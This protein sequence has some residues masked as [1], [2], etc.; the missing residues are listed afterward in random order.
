MRLL[1]LPTWTWQAEAQQH[2]SKAAPRTDSLR[3]WPS[4]GRNPPSSNHRNRKSTERKKCFVCDPQMLV[5]SIVVAQRVRCY[6]RGEPHEMNTI[7]FW[8]ERWPG[9]P[10]DCRSLPRY[11]KIRPVATTAGTAATAR[12]I[13]RRRFLL[14]FCAGFVWS[15]LRMAAAA[16]KESLELSN[17]A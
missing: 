1:D 16:S 2:K 10:C 14:S 17:H 9:T 12:I 7:C 5:L 15:K 6:L 11:F 3:I 13:R 8:Q 4:Q